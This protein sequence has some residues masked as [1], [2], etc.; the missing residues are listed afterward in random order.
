MLTT[1]ILIIII[2]ILLISGSKAHKQHRQTD[3]G[4]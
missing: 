4:L 2:V 3:N 1:A